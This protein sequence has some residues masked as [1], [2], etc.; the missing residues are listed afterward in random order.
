VT[1]SPAAVDNEETVEPADV[2]AST[3]AK[4]KPRGAQAQPQERQS[5]EISEGQLEE[6]MEQRLYRNDFGEKEV[7]DA[8]Q[9]RQQ[10]QTE[11]Q[12]AANTMCAHFLEPNEAVRLAS[13]TSEPSRTPLLLQRPQRRL[14]V[15]TTLHRLFFL[16]DSKV[17][18]RFVPL[19]SA[20]LSVSRLEDSRAFTVFAKGERHSFELIEEANS[21][22]AREEWVRSIAEAAQQ[23]REMT[24]T[25]SCTSFASASTSFASN[26]SA[27]PYSLSAAGGSAATS[28][29]QPQVVAAPA[30][31]AAVATAGIP[32]A[33]VIELAGSTGADVN[34]A[35]TLKYKHMLEPDENVVLVSI[36][37]KVRYFRKQRRL[38]VL[39]DRP[40]MFYA[41]AATDV[42]KGFIPL[43][44]KGLEARLVAPDAFV[45]ALD[46]K[47]YPFELP[48]PNA[49]LWVR[50]ILSARDGRGVVVTAKE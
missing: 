46:G 2:E 37:G 40:R 47:E 20:D 34:A 11:A 9:P 48:E 49:G 50:S 6:K 4:P 12:R 25:A 3:D 8:T 10:T 14:L 18:R 41:D 19:R 38:V 35:A 45:V 32:L 31:I 13:F 27:A 23:L 33:A 28:S 39:T 5:A 26:I 21:S 36:A 44:S 30:S 43:R 29:Q 15:L 42:V 17:V 16:D 24:S 1:A 22:E 7:V